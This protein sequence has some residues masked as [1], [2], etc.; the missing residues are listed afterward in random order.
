[1]RASR[2]Q[3]ED[4]A[5]ILIHDHSLMEVW[6]VQGRSLPSNLSA[7]RAA[8]L[9]VG[10]ARDIATVLGNQVLASVLSPQLFDP[11]IVGLNCKHY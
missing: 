6:P 8:Q 2:L 1:M 9:S 10:V 5:K 4:R 3:I 11:T 7:P